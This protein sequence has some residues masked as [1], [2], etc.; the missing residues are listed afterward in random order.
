MVHVTGPSKN[1]FLFIELLKAVDQAC[2]TRRFQRICLVA[3]NYKIHKAKAVQ[4]WLK[5][6]PRFEL[7]WL[8]TYCPKANPIERAF[9]DVHDKCTRNHRRKRLR[10]LMGDVL[11][12]LRVNGPWPYALSEI[13]YTPEV[14]AAVAELRTAAQLQA[15]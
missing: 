2:P 7:V 14:D 15:A 12:H 6:H 8:P 4:A 10:D 3:D 5:E 13:Y 9:G 11:R 1:R